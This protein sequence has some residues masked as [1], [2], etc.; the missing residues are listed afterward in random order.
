MSCRRQQL[1]YMARLS[2]RRRTEKFRTDSC[3]AQFLRSRLCPNSFPSC[4]RYQ[5]IS[6]YVIYIFAEK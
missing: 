5:H 2:D 4:N 3:F 1:Q 6:Y